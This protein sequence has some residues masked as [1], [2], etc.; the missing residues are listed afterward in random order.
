[1]QVTYK[2]GEGASGFWEHG[3]LPFGLIHAKERLALCTAQLEEGTTC[4]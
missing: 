2:K 3:Q 1:M 4:N